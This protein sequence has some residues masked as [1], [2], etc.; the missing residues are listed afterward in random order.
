[1]KP[2]GI[3][4]HSYSTVGTTLIFLEKNRILRYS[5]DLG[6]QSIGILIDHPYFWK[7]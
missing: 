6:I 4:V 1:M 5:L 7:T 3:S 2:E